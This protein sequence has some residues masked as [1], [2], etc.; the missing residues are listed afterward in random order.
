MTGAGGDVLFIEASLAPGDRATG[1]TLTGQLGDVMKE[2]A[3]IA[4]SYLSRTAPSSTCRSSV[5]KDR[6]VHVHVP[7]GAVPKDGPSAGVTMTTA[8]ASLLSGR[9]VRSDVAMTGEVSLTGR[10]LPIGGVKQKLLAAHR[11]GITTV[12][13]PQRNEPDLDDVPAAVREALTVHT[14][15]DVREVLS[16]ALEDAAVGASSLRDERQRRSS[17]ALSP[18]VRLAAP[19]QATGRAFADPSSRAVSRVA[20]IGQS[21]A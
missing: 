19:P 17:P 11:A 15:S 12:L 4:L 7:A 9:P 2:S 8:L 5:L 1:V 13:I 16:L 21:R 14:V 3:Q 10:V 20:A 6:G 18:P